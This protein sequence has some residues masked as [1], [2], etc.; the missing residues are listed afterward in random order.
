MTPLAGKLAR[1]TTVISGTT[2]QHE[3]TDWAL[4]INGDVID[5]DGFEKTADADG[6][7]WKSILIGL[8]GGEV[9]FEGRYNS[10]KTPTTSFKPSYAYTSLFC[11]LT[12]A[13]GFTLT[14]KCT[15]IG[16]STNV[17]DA[18]KVKGKFF[19]EGVTTYPT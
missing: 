18:G 15:Q 11:G 13:I 7:Y 2:V 19:V 8:V 17:K 14:G 1:L 16:A 12:S 5:V 3:F 9:D 6:S 10:A 4:S